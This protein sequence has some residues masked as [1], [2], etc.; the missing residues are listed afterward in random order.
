MMFEF[1]DLLYPIKALKLFG[2]YKKVFHTVC[3]TARVSYGAVSLSWSLYLQ[4][5]AHN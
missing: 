2:F 3:Q 5:V 4:S 1:T